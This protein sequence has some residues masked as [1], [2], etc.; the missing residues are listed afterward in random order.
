MN[1]HISF[2]DRVFLTIYYLQK[3]DPSLAD[4]ISSPTKD[5]ISGPSVIL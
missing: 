3:A 5:D 2:D 1:F 4:I